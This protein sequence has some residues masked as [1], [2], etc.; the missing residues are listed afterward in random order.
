MQ[1]DEREEKKMTMATPFQAEDQREYGVGDFRGRPYGEFGK[2]PKHIGY[3][4]TD[5]G[6]VLAQIPDNSEHGFFLTDGRTDWPGGVGV[7]AEWYALTDDDPYLCF[8][9]RGLLGEIISKA[10]NKS[11]H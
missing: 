11:G 9:D 4:F 2:H 7:A 10:R 1:V 6:H 5:R 3:V 8:G